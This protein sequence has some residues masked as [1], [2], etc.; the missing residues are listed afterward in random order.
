MDMA[1]PCEWFLKSIQKYADNHFVRGDV[2]E[3][4][5]IPNGSPHPVDAVVN[6]AFVM[7]Q[8]QYRSQI[9]RKVN[10][11]GMQCL[12]ARLMEPNVVYASPRRSTVQSMYGERDVTEDTRQLTHPMRYA[13]IR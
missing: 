7:G 10:A 4:E 1:P 2:S 5:D 6:W 12:A 3:L 13:N 9:E 11:L 8:Q